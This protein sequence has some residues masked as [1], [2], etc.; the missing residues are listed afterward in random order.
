MLD[1]MR[2]R[3]QLECVKMAVKIGSIS[4]R[5]GRTRGKK[6]YRGNSL[7]RQQLKLAK[8]KAGTDGPVG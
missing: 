6:P 2:G 1:K 5:K 8:E 7:V 3:G 4:D